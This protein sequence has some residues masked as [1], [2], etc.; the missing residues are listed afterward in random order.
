MLDALGTLPTPEEVAEFLADSRPDKRA[1][2]VDALLA[3]P[4]YVDYWTLQLADLLQ[5]RKERDHDVRGSKGVRSFHAWLRGE[6]AAN[7]PWNELA[8]TVLLASGDSI[9]RPEVG[10]YITVVGEKK[11]V[12]DSELPD[13]VAQS[14]LGTRIGCARC[15]N[16]P[17]EKY[18]QDDFYHFSAYFSK[19]ALERGKPETG[20]KLSTI[21]FDEQEQVKRLTELRAK[22]TEA[23]ETALRI[24]EEP[25]MDK[26]KK[27]L[28]E[29]QAKVAE[30]EKRMTELAKKP[31]Q[32]RQPRTSKMMAPQPLDGTKW[33]FEPGRDAREQ[34][35]NWMLDTKNDAFSGAIVNRLWKHFFSVGLVEPVDDL[36]ASNPP[37]N[38]ELWAVL[39]RE[40]VSSGYDLKHIVRLILNSRTYQL[41]SETRPENEADARYYSHYYARRLPAEVLTD[42]ISA[43]TDSPA[44][45]AGYPVG[46]RAIQL[47][48]PGVSSYFLTLF[49]RSTRD[50]L[51]L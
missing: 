27:E 48:E 41:S 35:V 21:S 46:M 11:N 23:E 30:V 38:P 20:T 33:Q 26:A 6:V 16:H 22:L 32:V 3:R 5:N 13:S 25:G 7:R 1:R 44:A 36:R 47:P 4:E 51:R 43:A 28:A 29:Q 39:K 34:L 17:L 2:L 18:T 9:S 50:R 37:S 10:Y 14:F 24:G 42:A 49:G 12:E 45:F 40:L 15:H 19:M 31:P 8:R